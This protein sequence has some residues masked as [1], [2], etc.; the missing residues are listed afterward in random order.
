MD[1]KGIRTLATAAQPLPEAPP[2]LPTLPF[3]SRHSLYTVGLSGLFLFSL[4]LERN[5]FSSQS[6]WLTDEA[7]R[8]TPPELSTFYPPPPT[9]PGE[10]GRVSPPP[11][12]PP[13]GAAV[14]RA[15]GPQRGVLMQPQTPPGGES[16]ARSPAPSAY[17]SPA[18]RTGH[19]RGEDNCW[20]LPRKP[21]EGSLGAPG[22]GHKIPA[23]PAREVTGRHHRD[24]AQPHGEGHH[25]KY[26]A[27]K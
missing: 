13:G 17:A 20:S 16:P 8:P 3:I 9:S 22:F 25:K 1:E 4:S 6:S 26:G 7:C 23:G 5:L 2:S 27:T 24:K 10:H 19:G 18:Q 12:G 15:P 11:P 21:H 14:H